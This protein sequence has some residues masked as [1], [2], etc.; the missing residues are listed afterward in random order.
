MTRRRA[1]FR[2]MHSP[3]PLPHLAPRAR[4]PACAAVS[5]VLAFA[6]VLL[7]PGSRQVRAMT[8][9][10]IQPRGQQQLL[11][12]AIGP[13]SRLRSGGASQPRRQGHRRTPQSAIPA[14]HLEPANALGQLI[15][16]TYAGVT[17]P[18][19][20]LRAVRAGQL[21][22]IILMG[23]NTAAGIASTRHAT[24][25]LQAAAH[26]GGNPGLLI[27]TDQEGGEV[28][29]LPG[30][31]IASASQM[32]SANDT[33]SQGSAAAALLRSAGVNVDLAPV[34]DVSR[35]DGFMTQEH[36]TFG[37]KPSQVAHAACAF[38]DALARG[39]VAYTLKHFP[40]LGDAAQSTDSVPVN[41]TESAS[42]IFADDAAYR[43]CGHGPL[44][45]VMVS[46][47]S[48]EHLTGVAPA[49]LSS[50]TYNTLLPN[51]GIDA[52]TISDSFESG[53]IA[54]LQAPALR[55]LNAGLDMVMYPGYESSSANAY[56]LLLQDLRGGALHRG[57]V[58]AAAQKVL[59]L[60]HNLG[61]G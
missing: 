27:M 14:S 13:A 49:V 7:S 55:A 40:G 26:A 43:L 60:K 38:A 45:L 58:E 19:S 42:N 31:P 11:P 59:A 2:G 18:G 20:I 57:R 24:T 3:F 51:D 34:A 10:K 8:R 54:G 41:V 22:A 46:S 29:R 25:E 52:V 17:P 15:I 30:P 21:G 44:A 33:H 4:L 37:S 39:G 47:A 23:D 32:A 6:V 5:V 50:Y 48:Y 35:I 56:R 61:L 9:P 53:S 12:R 16:G 28:R 1:S 36:R